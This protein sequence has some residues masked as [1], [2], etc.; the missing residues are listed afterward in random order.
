MV[1]TE[2][3]QPLYQHEFM[4]SEDGKRVIYNVSVR[5]PGFGV[6]NFCFSTNKKNIEKD[7]KKLN[8]FI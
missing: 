8:H 6:Q 3:R 5:V 2:Y 1:K 4:D 7:N